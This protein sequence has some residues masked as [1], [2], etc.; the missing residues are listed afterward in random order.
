[1]SAVDLL[2][3]PGVLAACPALVFQAPPLPDRSDDLAILPWRR[4]WLEA[5]ARGQACVATPAEL[6]GTWPQ[7][8][9]V[10][11]KERAGTLADLAA[12]WRH[13]A[14]D[15]R[16]VLVGDN[17][18]GIR[19][20]ARRWAE[21]GASEP[22]ALI[23]RAHARAFAWSR[24][25]GT[26]VSGPEEPELELQ[27]VAGRRR[28][29]SVPGVFSAT[30]VDAGSRLLIS[31][32]T[33]EASPLRVLDCC[34]G[35]GVLAAAATLHWP[36]AS[37]SAWDADARAVA[38]A[39][40]NLPAADCRWWD[41]DETPPASGYDLVLL[42]PPCHAGTRVDLGLPRRLFAALPGLLAPGGHALIVANRK[43]PYERDLSALG[44]VRILA[45]VDGFKL[46]DHGPDPA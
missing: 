4:T 16:L 40:R 24:S 42:N 6:T 19:A 43:L 9:V 14:P 12:A 32:L 5:R 18:V 25:P 11:G 10:A 1:M 22:E 39:A 44:S 3:D 45:Q 34:C 8:V 36:R 33:G 2:G 21:L 29:Q 31:R 15:G 13:L 41:V 27:T 38:C 35:V 28:L 17:A 20:T 26:D 7:A 23:A 37:V 30:A 46:I